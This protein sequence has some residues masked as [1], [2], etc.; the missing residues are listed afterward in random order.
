MEDESARERERERELFQLFLEFDICP[1][2]LGL[3]EKV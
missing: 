3:R 1:F 2:L